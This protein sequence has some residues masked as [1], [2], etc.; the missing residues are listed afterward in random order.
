[1]NVFSSALL[2]AACIAA[3][4]AQGQQKPYEPV[5]VRF[6]RAFDDDPGLKSLID[7]LHSAIAEKDVK[8]LDGALDTNF[9]ALEC[10]PSPLQICA[11]A[12]RGVVKSLARQPPAA[13][14]RAVLCCRDIAPKHVTKAMRE[15][16]VLGF[17]G[18][19]LEEGSLG[20]HPDLPGLACLPAWPLFDRAKASAIAL[21]ADIEPENLRVAMREIPLL[22]RPAS[23]AAEV[24]KL[25]LGQIA[26]LVSDLPD[27]LPDGWTAIALPQGGLGY[28]DLLGLN[29][30]A[31]GGLCFGKGTGGQWTIALTIQRRS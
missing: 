12:T 29:E 15:E 16:A 30:I 13:R 9:M 5:P 1:M 2:A 3:S 20:T 26:P 19:A 17:V 24:G 27:S 14:L 4:A 25:P 18:A 8:R 10:G 11:P 21:A 31:P 28:T 23:G 6:E 7:S 22:D